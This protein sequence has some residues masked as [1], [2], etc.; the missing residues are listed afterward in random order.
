MN[1]K[2][3]ETGSDYIFVT[4]DPL[5]RE[6]QLKSTTWHMHVTGGDHH[7][8]QFIGQEK[9]I[10]DII[11]DPA[12]ILPNDINDPNNTRQKYIDLAQLPGYNSLKAVVVVVDHKDEQFGD[13]VTV[14]PKNT[15]KSETGGAIYV[16]PKSTRSE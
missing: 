11:K 6:V 16:R 5:E 3:N 14:I 4:T 2:K 8:A 1:E 9:I 15:L 12:F 7:R 10:E 13:V